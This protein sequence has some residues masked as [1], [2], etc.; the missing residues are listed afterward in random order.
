MVPSSEELR[1]AKAKFAYTRFVSV[2]VLFVW[3]VKSF[4]F[5]HGYVYLDSSSGLF[6]FCLPSNYVWFVFL[7]TQGNVSVPSRN[8]GAST[9]NA[10]IE[11]VGCCGLTHLLFLR[12]FLGLHAREQRHARYPTRFLSCNPQTGARGLL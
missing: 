8:T 3:L 1:F 9:D 6:L 5:C 7:C 2:S 4:S 12:R 10:D 11:D